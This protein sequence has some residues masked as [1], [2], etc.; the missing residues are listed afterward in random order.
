[1]SGSLKR[2]S[3][4]ADLGDGRFMISELPGIGGLHTYRTDWSSGPKLVPPM[5]AHG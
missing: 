2:V 5:I 4:I 3:I 1:M